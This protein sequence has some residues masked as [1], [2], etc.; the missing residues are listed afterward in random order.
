MVVDILSNAHPIIDALFLDP[1]YNTKYFPKNAKPFEFA[2]KMYFPA[3]IIKVMRDILNGIIDFDELFEG[4]IDKTG[5]SR[6]TLKIS[7]WVNIVNTKDIGSRTAN[8][9]RDFID[10]D[11]YGIRKTI[12]DATNEA[13]LEN[14]IE[15]IEKSIIAV[16]LAYGIQEYLD[17]IE[18][19]FSSK[20]KYL[21]PLRDPP[22]SI[23]PIIALDDSKDIG[24]I[25][26]NVAAVFDSYKDRPIDYISPKNIQVG[27]KINV[28]LKKAVNDWLKY[29]GVA[30]G[31]KTK[32]M[33]KYGVSLSVRMPNS[34]T[35]HDFANVGVGVS[36]VFPIVVMCLI[37]DPDTSF[38]F[39]QP[40]LHLHPRVQSRLADFFLSMTFIHKQCIIETHSEYLINKI[41]YRIVEEKNDE[42][43]IRNS[44]KLYFAE[45]KDDYTNFKELEI[46]N[47]GVISEWPDG[48]FDEGQNLARDILIAGIE[49]RKGGKNK[50]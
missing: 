6:G 19:Y 23:Y 11:G 44:V 37:A 33:G 41:R 13:V 5:S 32:N 7:D 10:L 16:D 36:Q 3:T 25:G 2:Q 4:K 35:F 12:Y 28:P 40:E 49:K 47:Y 22:K 43:K 18:N 27:K 20:L 50:R 24:I 45:K 46:N 14:N 48:F 26:E 1:E 21:G 34:K 38:L 29:L 9:F 39:E 8:A 30:D 42:T 15:I 17:Y 31:V